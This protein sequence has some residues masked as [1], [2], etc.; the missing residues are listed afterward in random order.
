MHRI[1]RHKNGWIAS[2]SSGHS[3]NRC[4]GM[5]VVMHVGIV[6][7]DLPSP[8]QRSASVCLT[9][10]ETVHQSAAKIVCARPLR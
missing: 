10:D 2:G 7:H 1:D 6:E 9:F 3:T 8:A 5:P 4:L